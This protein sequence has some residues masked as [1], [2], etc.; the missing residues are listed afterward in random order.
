MAMYLCRT[1]VSGGNDGLKAGC[2]IKDSYV[3]DITST[4]GTNMMSASMRYSPGQYHNTVKRQASCFL[5]MDGY[6]TLKLLTTITDTSKTVTLSVVYYDEF[7]NPGT[8]AVESETI[9]LSNVSTYESYTLKNHKYVKF[10]ANPESYPNGMSSS[11]QNY[12]VTIKG[13]VV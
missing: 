9:T 5:N 1:N 2:I 4:S 7:P 8:A 10:N 13:Y 11:S 6:T 12:D 3:Y